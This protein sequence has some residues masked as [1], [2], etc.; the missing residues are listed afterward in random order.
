MCGGKRHG[1]DEIIT[2]DTCK[3]HNELLTRIP[4]LL[5]FFFFLQDFDTVKGRFNVNLDTGKVLALRSINLQK[6]IPSSSRDHHQAQDQAGAPH[7]E[8]GAGVAQGVAQGIAQG[9]RVR[10]VKTSRAELN[11]REG[12]IIYSDHNAMLDKERWQVRGKGRERRGEA[13]AGGA[14]RGGVPCTG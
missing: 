14:E 10:V 7:V 5:F 3:I 9:C 1:A 4:S 13:G 11:G 12:T 8:Q 2:L 6:N